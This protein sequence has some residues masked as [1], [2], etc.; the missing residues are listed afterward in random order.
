MAS[1]IFIPFFAIVLTVLALLTHYVIKRL[2]DLFG[3]RRDWRFYTVWAASALAFIAGSILESRVSTPLTRGIYAAGA[4]VLGTAFIFACVLLI[5][6]AAHRL[7]RLKPKTWGIIILTIA[8]GLTIIALLC[9]QLLTVDHVEIASPKVKQEVRIVQLSDVHLGPVHDKAYLERVA[10][11]ARELNPDAIVITGDLIDDSGDYD[12][13]ILQPL[14]ALGKPVFFVAGNHEGFSGATINRLLQNT[15][16]IHL[17]DGSAEFGGI[18]IVGID[19]RNSR[20]A[21]AQTLAGI[22]F[23]KTK[24]TVLLYHRPSASAALNNSGVDLMLSGHTHGGQIFP[25]TLLVGL[26]ERPVMGLHSVNGMEVYVST[27]T[28]TWG[29]PMRLGSTE[30]ITLITIKPE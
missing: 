8:G 1:L 3:T 26:V 7:V 11:K 14:D 21:V 27:G 19:D 12:P 4:A 10:R 24:Y 6:E 30:S 9:A 13:S 29:P 22:P 15:S 16:I 28:G 5:Y 17:K 2:F 20:S 23:D 18:Q 25:F